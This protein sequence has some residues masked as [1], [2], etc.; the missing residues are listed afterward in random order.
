M[1]AKKKA[2]QE[3]LLMPRKAQWAPSPSFLFLK[4]TKYR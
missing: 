2:Y 3:L 4:K 1:V